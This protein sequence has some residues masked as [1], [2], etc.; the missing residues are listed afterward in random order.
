MRSGIED[1]SPNDLFKIQRKVGTN[2]SLAGNFT[3]LTEVSGDGA[4]PNMRLSITPFRNVWWEVTAD[5]ACYSVTTGAWTRIDT[6][7][8]IGPGNQTATNASWVQGADADGR[9]KSPPAI[10]TWNNDAGASFQTVRPS[11]VFKLTAGQT[12]TTTALLQPVSGTWSYW[13]GGHLGI[14]AKVVGFW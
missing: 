2:E 4:T 8:A 5:I 11:Y 14:Y 6:A 13:R 12:Y 1:L 9:Q 3:G 10:L 7:L